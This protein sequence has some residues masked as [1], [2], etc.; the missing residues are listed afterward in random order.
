MSNQPRQP[1]DPPT[2]GASPADHPPGQGEH[3]IPDGQAGEDAA[4]L[5]TNDRHQ[6]E[7][8]TKRIGPDERS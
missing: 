4:A 5:P 2:E 8:A 3:G 6:T 7:T 1:A